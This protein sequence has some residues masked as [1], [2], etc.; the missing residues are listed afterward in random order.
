MTTQYKWLPSDPTEEMLKA[1][2]YFMNPVAKALY[3]I[4]WQ[5]A[6]ESKQD[7]VKTAWSSVDDKLPISF[8]NVLVMDP[9]EG[10]HVAFHNTQYDQ[11]FSVCNRQLYDVT[12]WMPIPEY[13]GQKR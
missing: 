4:M 11:W 7:A 8:A 12:H 2:D 9:Q 13:E 6:P 5:A 3:E 1:V 10:Y